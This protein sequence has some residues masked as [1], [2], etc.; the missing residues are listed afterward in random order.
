MIVLDTNVVS[1]VMKHRPSSPVLDWLEQTPANYLYISVV[2]I[3]EIEYG[4]RSLPSGKRRAQ[5]SG[6]FERFLAQ[7]FSG[8]ILAFEQDAARIYG[9]I[10]SE[11][12]SVGRPMGVADGQIAATTRARGFA[13]ATR[14]TNDFVDCGLELIDPFT[15]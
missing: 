12:R 14:N 6:L 3:A 10:M 2:T 9:D 8:R 5:L 7:A 13:L 11:R 4:L 15:K 1:E